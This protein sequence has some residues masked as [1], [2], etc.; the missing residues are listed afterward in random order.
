MSTAPTVPVRAATLEVPDG[1]LY[2]EVRGDGPLV[3]LVASPMDARAFAPLAD[4]LATDRTVLTT[5][6][7]G[8]GRSVLHDPTRDSTPELRAADVARLL[9]HLDRGPAA[10][11]GSSGGA[12]TALA[13]L[14]AQP[15]LVSSVV[16][17]E[18][19]L[20]ELVADRER[21][22][23]G[24]QEIVDTYLAGDPVQAWRQFMALADIVMPEE[25]FAH[26]FGGPR[27]PERAAEERRF[28]AHEI[29]STTRWQPD[30]DLLRAAGP[31]VVVGVGEE[32]AGQLA[33]RTS[34]ALADALGLVPVVFPGG[35]TGF[36]DD[37]VAFAARL[38]AVLDKEVLAQEVPG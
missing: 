13:L 9:A 31:R 27:S 14:Q 8:I 17:H 4:L 6:P 36:E 1:H 20:D 7:R 22:R 35:H 38:R 24:T 15:D 32:S 29:L 18:A 25:L 5:D 23:A 37:P 26:L 30:L 28:F 10:V 12:V 21:L 3:A 11:L 2:Y 16:A 19:P 34:R 33:E